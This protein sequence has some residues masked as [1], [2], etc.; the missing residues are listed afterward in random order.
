MRCIICESES[1]FFFSKTYREPPFAEFMK[2]VGAVEYYKCTEC[3]FVLSKT[4]SELSARTWSDLNSNFHNYLET[5]ENEKIVNQPPYVEQAVMLSILGQEGIINLDSILDYAAGYGSLSRL[6]NKY[7]GI[8]LPIFD[9]FFKADDAERYVSHSELKTYKT[10]LNSAM[11]EHV[12]R[13]EDL[14]SVNRL[15]AD[16]SQLFERVYNVLDRNPIYTS[17]NPAFFGK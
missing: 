9:P 3:G 14:D 10:V 12:L 4:H 17:L 15:V 11:F 13:R 5:A 1:K 2:E 6:L 7:F 16:D 8:E